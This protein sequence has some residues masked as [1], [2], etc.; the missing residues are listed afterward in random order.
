MGIRNLSTASISTGTKRSKFWDQSAALF[1]S[2]FQAIATTRVTSAT[3]NIV[4]DNIP[5]NFK[6]LQI[7]L[8]GRSTGGDTGVGIRY[9][10]TT[11][12][13]GYVWQRMYGDG[14]GT[15]TDAYSMEINR[16][17][18]TANFFAGSIIDIFN[19]ADSSKL[20][21]ANG[22]TGW[23]INSGSTTYVAL[24]SSVYSG[25]ALAVTKLTLSCDTMGGTSQ[26]APYTRASLYGWK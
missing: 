25:A 5:Q 17:A 4:F 10:N 7:R 9:N 21:S 23:H 19:Y 3:T 26:F 24:Q 15:G 12:S 22:I 20:K 14:S 11:G 2:D 16:T 1:D 8:F 13:S 6:H 18:T